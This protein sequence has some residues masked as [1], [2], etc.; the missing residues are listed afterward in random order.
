LTARGSHAPSLRTRVQRLLDD[1]LHLQGASIVCACSGGPD[2]TAMLHVLA[3]LRSKLGLAVHACA[4]DHGLRPEAA[5]EIEIAQEVAAS[6]EVPFAVSKVKVERGANLMARARESRYRALR[7]ARARAG[8]DFI[9]TGH[10]ADDRAETL[11]LRLLRGAGP[12]GLAVL[13]PLAGDLLRPLIRASRADVLAHLH[14]AGI[15][16]ATDPS[17]ED[18]RFLRVRVRREVMPLL[19]SLSPRLVASLC[20]LADEIAELLPDVD[21]LAT[22]GRRQRQMLEAALKRG[23]GAARVRTSDHE[24][25]LVVLENGRKVLR[26]LMSE[27]PER[28]AKK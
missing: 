20:S 19:E 17:N 23:S 7:Q 27:K 1:E 22:L 8:A 12:R 28:R 10:T 15:R 3:G 14:R 2:S 6:L 9:A 18:P 26:E 5:A 21:P 25:V 16:Y 4:V 13:P 11:V 24:E